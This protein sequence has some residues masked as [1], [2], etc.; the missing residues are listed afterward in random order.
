MNTIFKYPFHTEDQIDL[1]MPKGAKVLC[2]Q[3][4][5]QVPCIWALVDTDQP[6]EMRSFLVYGTGH[7]LLPEAFEKTYIGT[8]Q[9]FQGALVFHVFER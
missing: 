3:L 6:L 7:Q 2:V 9:E 8:Y 5:A 1:Q 4:Q